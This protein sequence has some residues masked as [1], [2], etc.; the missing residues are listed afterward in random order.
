MSISI[1]V[2]SDRNFITC[3]SI[4]IAS[5]LHYHPDDIHVYL[6]HEKLTAEDWRPLEQTISKLGRNCTFTP[7]PVGQYNWEGFPTGRNYPLATYYRLNLPALL[8]NVDKVIYLDG[9]IVMTDDIQKAWDL[10]MKDY[11]LAAMSIRSV[12]SV[13]P[14]LVG[15]HTFNAGFL[16][17]NLKR[18][19]ETGAL[20][21]IKRIASLYKNKLNLFDQDILNLVFCDETLHLPLRW[22]LTTGALKREDENYST[23]PEEELCEAIRHPAV[24]HFTTSAKPW[25]LKAQIR[26]PFSSLY[27]YF[28][29]LAQT[30]WSFRFVL[31]LK[32]TLKLNRRFRYSSWSQEHL[33]EIQQ[34][35]M[36]LTQK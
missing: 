35:I 12:H 4:T 8:P 13:Y 25:K 9:D 26:H 34:T 2:S 15:K 14:E 36:R 17:M 19:R 7:V 28:A 24:I 31:F 3:T 18:M 23:I 11:S 22:N 29:K 16:V 32:F 30:P 1:A 5:I 10:D 33:T 6:L 20:V 27:T 21:N